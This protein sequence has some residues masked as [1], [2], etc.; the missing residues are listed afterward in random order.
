MDGDC[1]LGCEPDC[2]GGCVWPVVCAYA[3][4]LNASN[5][6]VHVPPAKT[7]FISVSS[8]KS[9][10]SSERNCTDGA[11]VSR[12]ASVVVANAAVCPAARERLR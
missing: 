10:I 1:E 8:R 2:P 12:Y 11:N 4:R 5:A 9:Q 6:A 3:A 7:D